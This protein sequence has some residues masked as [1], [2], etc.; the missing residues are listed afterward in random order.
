MKPEKIVVYSKNNCP[1]CVAAKSLLANK[2]L[3]FEEIDVGQDSTQ[4]Q[5]MIEKSQRRTVPQIF[6]DDEHIG[7]FVELRDLFFKQS[8]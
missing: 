3:S 4:L 7:G 6:F 5:K 1:Y 8:A 2:G